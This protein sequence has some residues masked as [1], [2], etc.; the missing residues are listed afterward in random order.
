MDNFITMIG[1]HVHNCDTIISNVRIF[2]VF[3]VGD[4][5]PTMGPAHIPDSA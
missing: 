3:V 5:S 4:Y 2:E 1:Q